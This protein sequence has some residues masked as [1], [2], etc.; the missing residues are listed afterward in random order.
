MKEIRIRK[1]VYGMELL[2]MAFQGVDLA[3][4]DKVKIVV[5]PLKL[6]DGA[7]YR[8]ERVSSKA[9]LELRVHIWDGSTR[10]CG[11]EVAP[12]AT[13]TEIVDQARL[14]IADEPLEEPQYYGIFHENNEA[15][16]PWIQK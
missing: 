2:A 15:T 11:I 14:K 6:E 16:Q 8:I 4:S 5:K 10:K 9:R 3:P 13:L 1:D 7:I 12:N